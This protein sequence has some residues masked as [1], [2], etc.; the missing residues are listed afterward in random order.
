MRPPRLILSETDKHRSADEA[1]MAYIIW[2]RQ[3]WKCWWGH[4]GLYYLKQTNIEVLMRPPWLI[5]SE[6]DKHRSADEASTAYIIWNRQ[7]WKCWWGLHGLYYLKQTNMEVLMWPTR[8]ILSETDKHRSADETSMAYIIWNRQTWK[9]WWGHHGLLYLKQ[10]NMEV[11]MRPPRLILSETDKHD[12]PP[13]LRRFSSSMC[14]EVKVYMSLDG[15]A[16]WRT[17]GRLGLKHHGSNI[18]CVS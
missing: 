15:V 5:L 12:E 10:T 3:I 8:L 4:H 2:N 17:P 1:S 16:P 14:T 18:Y 7:T 9:C 6:T 11:L 13:R